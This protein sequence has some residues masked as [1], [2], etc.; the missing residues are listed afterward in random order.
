MMGS[1]RKKWKDDIKLYLTVC[2]RRDADYD[3][4]TQPELFRP[5][6]TFLRNSFINEDLDFVDFGGFEPAADIEAFRL[7]ISQLDDNLIP[8]TRHAGEVHDRSRS[9]GYKNLEQTYLFIKP[10]SL[11][12]SPQLIAHAVRAGDHRPRSERIRKTL[13]QKNIPVLLNLTSNTMTGIAPTVQN[14]RFLNFLFEANKQHQS[15]LD[16]YENLLFAF[17]TDDPTIMSEEPTLSLQNEF[18]EIHKA[19][20]L[21]SRKRTSV[22]SPNNFFD[23]VEENLNRIIRQLDNRL[24]E[25][26]IQARVRREQKRRTDDAMRIK[27]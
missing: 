1:I 23:L 11:T 25:F 13:N 21:I 16:R 26:R 12:F 27:V 20:D 9:I 5:T 17:C 7:F 15:V 19:V 10:G 22:L 2:F 6:I 4:L 24:F 18:G 8:H 14:H 3:F